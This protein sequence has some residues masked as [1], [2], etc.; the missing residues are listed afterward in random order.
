[1]EEK[2]NSDLFQENIIEVF[3]SVQGEG[4]YVG[5][6]QIFV[7]FALCNLDCD[8]CDTKCSPQE[9]CNFEICPGSGSFK[10][11]RNPVTA[12]Q[13]IYKINELNYFNHHSLSLTGGEPLLCSDFLNYFLPEFKKENKNIK[14]YLETNGTLPDKLENVI[15]NIDIISMDFKLESSTGKANLWREHREFIE[16]AKKYNKEIFAKAIITSKITQKEI[17]E[18]AG[19]IAS[20]NQAIP[21]ILQPLSSENKDLLPTSGM[22]L[23]I[24]EALLRT[25]TDV[26]IIP[27]VHKYLGLY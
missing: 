16:V 25:L 24:Q 1:M 13:L 4:P 9:Y 26:R 18:M 14:I 12:E 23:N 2:M 19:L 17:K 7:R 27:Q 11:V 15:D 3:S 20:L 5:C 21:L 10:Q 8:Y 22:L 6:R